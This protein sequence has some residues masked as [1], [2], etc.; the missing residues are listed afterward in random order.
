M[1][2]VLGNN[3]LA[4]PYYT[5]ADGDIHFVYLN[6]AKEP[7]NDQLLLLEEENGTEAL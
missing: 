5:D 6:A 1:D 3:M 2:D 7:N 4:P